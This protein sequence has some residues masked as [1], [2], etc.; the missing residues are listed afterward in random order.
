MSTLHIVP[1]E[2][3]AGSLRVALRSGEDPYARV[4][5]FPDNFSFGPIAPGDPMVR[6]QWWGAF[7]PA[8]GAS[9]G[10]ELPEF[11]RTLETTGD[12]RV[13]VWFSRRTA[14]EL[15]FFLAVTE[16]LGARPFEVIEVGHPPVRAVAALSPDQMANL[17]GSGHPITDDQ[18]ASSQQH[19]R[20]L[21]GENATF[22]V[23]VGTGL[24]SAPADHFDA[25]LLAAAAS[26]WQPVHRI[27]GQVMGDNN[28]ADMP[29]FWR[30]ATLVAT[31]ELIADGDPW[32]V[33]T[34]KVRLPE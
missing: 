10:P 4:L 18:R 3:A 16:R 32:A 29:L 5:A 31:G 8:A 9:L 20:Q 28:I 24:A 14:D 34:T 6:M 11:W 17:L 33:R 12:D 1:S 13:V 26:R 2:P 27:V 15:A 23:V 19:W 21:M 30:V 7:P 25:Q 22:R